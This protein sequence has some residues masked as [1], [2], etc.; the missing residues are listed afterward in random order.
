MN[1]NLSAADVMA[2]TKDGDGMNSI[3]NNPGAVKKF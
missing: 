3:W 2:L 1:E